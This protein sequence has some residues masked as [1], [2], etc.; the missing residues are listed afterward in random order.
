MH[1][2]HLQLARGKCYKSLLY[3][4]QSATTM[5][6]RSHYSIGWMDGGALQKLSSGGHQLNSSPP[7]LEHLAIVYFFRWV[8]IH[9]IH[10]TLRKG[11]DLECKDLSLPRPPHSFSRSLVV[12][13]EEGKYNLNENGISENNI[14]IYKRQLNET[15]FSS[16]STSFFAIVLSLLRSAT[17]SD[18]GLFVYGIFALI[19]I[20]NSG[21]GSYRPCNT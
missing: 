18:A 12:R 8:Q 21:F 4:T 1:T 16:T 9:W 2:D 10:E 20:Q 3:W 13:Y 7:S 15:Y 14:T 5:S 6:W 19:I 17:C 11:R